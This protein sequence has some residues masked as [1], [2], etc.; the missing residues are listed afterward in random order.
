M[1]STFWEM[2]TWQVKLELSGGLETAAV[3]DCFHSVTGKDRI[4]QRH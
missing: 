4:P 2:V 3:L 1:D